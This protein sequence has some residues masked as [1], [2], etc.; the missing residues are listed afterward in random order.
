MNSRSASLF[1]FVSPLIGKLYPLRSASYCSSAEMMDHRQREGGKGCEREPHTRE[2]LELALRVREVR[3]SLAVRH[4]RR[5]D[6]HLVHSNR[7]VVQSRVQSD[8]ATRT[9]KAIRQAG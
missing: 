6:C 5:L 8:L 3:R 2:M 9:C 4:D 1:A 7:R